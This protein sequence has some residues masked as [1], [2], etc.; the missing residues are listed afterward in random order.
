[1][2]KDAQVQEYKFMEGVMLKCNYKKIEQ[3]IKE[4]YEKI[5]KSPSRRT[6]EGYNYN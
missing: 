5:K 3:N 1:M 2:K 4:M 6:S